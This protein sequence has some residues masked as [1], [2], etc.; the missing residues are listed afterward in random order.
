[1]KK[2]KIIV[3]ALVF[4]KLGTLQG[5]EESKTIKTKFAGLHF[6]VVHPILATNKDDTK[7][8]ADENFYTVGF[9]IG[10][11]FK[12]ASKLMFDLEFVPFIN[13]GNDTTALQTHLLFH[14]GI[15]LPLNKGF[16]LG[17]RAAF[18]LGQGQ[19][20]FSPLINKAFKYNDTSAFFIELVLPGRFGPMNDSGYTQIVAL[21]L[22]IGI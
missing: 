18:E 22:G 14:P 17:A 2:L 21:H 6:G 4:L 9:P 10:V 1:M 19:V 3:L 12:T 7:T 13:P 11:T 8:I 5:Q 15:L 16:T 20:G